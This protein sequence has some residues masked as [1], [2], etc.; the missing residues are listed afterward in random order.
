MS[1]QTL[2]YVIFSMTTLVH[3]LQCRLLQFFRN[4]VGKCSTIHHTVLIWVSQTRTYSRNS[5][6]RSMRGEERREQ[7][8]LDKEKI[9]KKFKKIFKFWKKIATLPEGLSKPKTCFPRERSL[10]HNF[11]AKR[12]SP[13][14][15]GGRTT[16]AGREGAADGKSKNEPETC[17]TVTI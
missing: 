15:P 3:I 9:Q 7:K 5:R 2:V 11:S 10:S 13:G 4:M 16:S 17:L 6:S 8:F 1:S 12:T 14:A